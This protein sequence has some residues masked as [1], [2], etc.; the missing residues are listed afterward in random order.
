M[1]SDGSIT[2]IPAN[3]E[4]NP[5]SSSRQPGKKLQQREKSTKFWGDSSRYRLIKSKVCC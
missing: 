1:E 5:I 4:K 3:K 2:I